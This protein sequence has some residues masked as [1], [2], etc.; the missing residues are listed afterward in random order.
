MEPANLQRYGK[1]EVYA[2][3]KIGHLTLT[4]SAV[5]PGELLAR[6]RSLRGDLT[7]ESD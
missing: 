5:D 4:G 2:P 6:V 1:N 7:F 3:R